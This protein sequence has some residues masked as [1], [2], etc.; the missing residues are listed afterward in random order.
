ME[1]KSDEHR[2]HSH[3]RASFCAV[4]IRRRLFELEV[5]SKRFHRACDDADR[6][7]AVEQ[8]YL[9]I[10]KIV[11]AL[12]FI[13]VCSHEVAEI[14]LSNRIRDGW[15]AERLMGWLVSINPDFF[16]CPID[17]ELE[18]E[19]QVFV[20]ARGRRD[21]LDAATAR[22]FYLE[23][24]RL[25]H[26]ARKPID[27]A[28]LHDAN[29]AAERFQRKTVNLLHL[30]DVEMKSAKF[31]LIG[32]LNYGTEKPPEVFIGAVDAPA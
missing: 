4:L 25:L 24:G 13:S 30:F 14:E 22:T 27:S 23:S 6:L 8:A 28:D 2:I 1:E 26:E 16:P 31:L 29:R 17:I 9:H 11:E 21:C 10:R 32:Q 18:G 3:A 7:F 19:T 20:D 12:M 5:C 15:N